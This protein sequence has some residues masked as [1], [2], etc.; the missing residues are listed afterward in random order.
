MLNRNVLNWVLF[1]FHFVLKQNETKIQEKNK[2]RAQG[3]S[4]RI[5]FW[6]TRSFQFKTLQMI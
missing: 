2:L 1:S 5:F 3:Q 4:A 6:P